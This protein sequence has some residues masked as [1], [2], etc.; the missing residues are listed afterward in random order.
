MIEFQQIDE[1]Q[2]W[3]Q[4]EAAAGRSRI[5]VPT[6]GGLHQGHLSL[7][8]I[9]KKRAGEEGEVVVSL[10]VNPT[11]FG[12]GEDLA[13][14]P[15]TLDQDR[16]GCE[17]S[18]VDVLFVPEA[19]VMYAK[20]ASLKVTEVKLSSGLCGR[21]R[22]VHFDGVCTIVSKLFNLI[23]PQAAV[24]GEKDFQQLAIIRRLVRDLNYPIEIIGGP[25]VREDDG[26][27]MSTRNLNLSSDHRQEA[28][29]L[30]QALLEA[31]KMLGDGERNA[32]HIQAHVEKR[33][34]ESPS[35]IPN[36]VEVVHP[37][38]LQVLDEVT[39]ALL[40]AVAVFFGS[41]RLIDNLCWRE[42][43]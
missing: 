41:T 30:R 1:L 34:M 21:T 13:A 6:M 5:L 12:P 27:A 31:G 22:P 23:Q 25:I 16:Q 24:F 40:V 39:D 20:D 42:E 29:V 26:L 38:T 37:D 35:A 17:E 32:E 28:V 18:G 14:Y 8:D 4:Q 2:Q 19:G 15:K 10:F 3:V 11:Q 43:K 33:L 7:M 36:Y 9:A